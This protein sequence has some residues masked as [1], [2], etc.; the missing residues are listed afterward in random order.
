MQWKDWLDLIIKICAGFGGLG[1]FIAALNYRS[2]T[3][4]KRAEWLKSLFE[5]FFETPGYKEVRI[6]L[7]YG[8]L[9]EKLTI[10]NET[11]RMKNEEQFT[12]FLNFFEFIGIFSSEKLLTYKQVNNVFD[13]Y[14]KKIKAD[15]DCMGWIRQYGFEKLEAMLKKI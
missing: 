12:D 5:K 7:D 15:P 8:K 4:I 1:F 6:W 3:K 13:Y 11:E 2:Q 10:A 14:L 9:H